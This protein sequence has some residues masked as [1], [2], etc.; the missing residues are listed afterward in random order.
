MQTSKT[1]SKLIG[2]RVAVVG[3][4]GSGKS[5]LAK[6]IAEAKSLGYINADELFWLPNWV[7]RTKPEYYALVEQAMTADAW[8]YDG[9]IGGS[10]HIVLPRIDTLIWLDYTRPVV[11]CRLFARTVRR[12]WTKEVIFSGNAESWRMSFAS[13]HSILLYAWRSHEKRKKQYEAL[14]S[15]LDPSIIKHRVHS[16]RDLDTLL[17]DAGLAS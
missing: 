6:K 13:K 11:M 3:C 5:T 4:S 1:S 10:S 15:K 2:Q 9:N 12:A 8:V 14:W 17:K 16:Q 7:E